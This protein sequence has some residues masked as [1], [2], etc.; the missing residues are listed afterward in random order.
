MN[1]AE[2]LHSATE[3]NLMSDHLVRSKERKKSSLGSRTPVTTRIGIAAK[4]LSI[5]SRA[6]TLPAS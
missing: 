6:S 4:A 1:Q 2:H 3:S 5:R